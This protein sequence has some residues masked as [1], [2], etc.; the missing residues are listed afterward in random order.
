MFNFLKNKLKGVL[1]KFT[2]KVEEE[3]PEEKV[4]VEKE[5]EVVPPKVEKK[6]QIPE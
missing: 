4:T 3:A 6:L 2:K 1:S 5:V